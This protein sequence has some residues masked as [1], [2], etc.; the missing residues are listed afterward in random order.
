MVSILGKEIR[1]VNHY[2]TGEHCKHGGCDVQ[3]FDV[4]EVPV[5][6]SVGCDASSDGNECDC[7]EGE[8]NR[9]TD[10]VVIVC[11]SGRIDGCDGE[12][13]GYADEEEGDND[14]D[15]EHFSS[16]LRTVPRFC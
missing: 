12:C 4:D 9:V 8:S 11:K 1:T 13:R 2:A 5:R 10:V 7:G 6:V 16:F 14:G 3:P 15:G